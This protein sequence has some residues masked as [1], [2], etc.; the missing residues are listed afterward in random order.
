MHRRLISGLLLAICF[1]LISL[2]P[3]G[4]SGATAP[5]VSTSTYLTDVRA[6]S[7]ALTRY[8]NILSRATG[9]GDIERQLKPL[10]KNLRTFDQRVYV[11][12]RYRLADPTLNRQRAGIARTGAPLL[13]SLSDF[14]D[15]VI[16]DRGGEVDRLVR[17]IE[18]QTAAFERAAGTA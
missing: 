2:L 11:M 5:V 16:L 15:A 7:G 1:G 6:A 14:V 18:R 4:A 13:I 17:V 3:T 12:S 10:R 8:G 9:V